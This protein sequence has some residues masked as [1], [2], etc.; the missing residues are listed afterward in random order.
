MHHAGYDP[1]DIDALDVL[2]FRHGPSGLTLAGL[3]MLALTSLVMAMFAL[4]PTAPPAAVLA[5]PEAQARALAAASR[6]ATWIAAGSAV[7]FV[8]LIRVRESV[9]DFTA[10]TLTLT[11]TRAFVLRHR[12]TWPFDAL[13]RMRRH[14]RYTGTTYVYLLRVHVARGGSVLLGPWGVDPGLGH[15]VRRVTGQAGEA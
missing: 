8:F 9:F 1:G 11:D 14:R 3:V 5:G 12:R 7:A 6:L 15:L 10:Q 2:R 13:T 4:S